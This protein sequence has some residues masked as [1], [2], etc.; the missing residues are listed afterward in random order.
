MIP[1]RYAERKMF[2]AELLAARSRTGRP[3][4]QAARAPEGWPRGIEATSRPG[5]RAGA[6]QQR[7]RELGCIWISFSTTLENVLIL[8]SVQR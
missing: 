3:W 5:K 4:D 1:D 2:Y 6:F 7:P 8:T